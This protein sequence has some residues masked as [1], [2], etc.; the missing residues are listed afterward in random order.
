MIEEI[1]IENKEEDEKNENFE[2]RANITSIEIPA[3]VTSIGS[4]AFN[5]CSSI[6]EQNEAGI[7]K[8]KL[9]TYFGHCFILKKD[10]FDR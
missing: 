1:N 4:N 5:N 9:N 7:S 10:F 2:N 3:S 6:V 8:P